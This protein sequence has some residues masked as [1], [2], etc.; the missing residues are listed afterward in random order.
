MDAALEHEVA[1]TASCRGAR[2]A[3]LAVT[4]TGDASPD[5]TFVD[6]DNNLNTTVTRRWRRD[7]WFFLS[8]LDLPGLRRRPHRA[9]VQL[10][11]DRQTAVLSPVTW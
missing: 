9:C 8:R 2:H 10:R 11:L 4:E 6:F 1:I 5:H 3:R 7:W